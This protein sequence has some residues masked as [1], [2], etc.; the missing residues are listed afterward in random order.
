MRRRLLVSL[1]LA[2]LGVAASF[3]IV[4]IDEREV[5]FRTILNESDPTLFGLH[6]NQPVIDQ[7]GWYI[8]IPFLH[9]LYRYP[10]QRLHYAAQPFELYTSDKQLIEGDFAALVPSS[11]RP[12][13]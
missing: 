11:R 10:R 12:Q 7:P 6:L 5:A 9:Q 4:I 13:V 1:L 8:R 2:T 3:C